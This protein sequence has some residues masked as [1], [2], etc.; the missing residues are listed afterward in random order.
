M[1]LTP[2]GATMRNHRTGIGALLAAGLLLFCAVA[3][4]QPGVPRSATAPTQV[5]TSQDPL[6]RT[7]PRG[8]VLGFLLAAR[9]GDNEAAAQYLNTD[10]HGQAAS[11]LAHELFVVLDRRLPARL[12]QLSDKP[13]GSLPFLTRLDQD[14]VGTITT[15]DG[16]VD[17][18]VERVDRGN[19]NSIWLFSRKTLA[20]IPGL[21]KELDA[22]EVESVIPGFLVENS[23]AGVALFEWLAVLVGLPV[24]YLITS[25]LNYVI[26]SLIRRILRHR[27]TRASLS[28]AEFLP[29]PV[30]LLLIALIIRWGLSKVT[31][32][33][34]A[35]EFWSNTAAVITITACVWLLILLNG[36]VES[37]ML[38]RMVRPNRG[39]TSILTLGRRAVDSMAV[40]AGIL[41]GFHHFGVNLTAALAGLGVGGIAIALAAQKTLENVIG[42]IS[43][44]FD[45]VIREGDQVKVGDQVGFVEHIG[46]RSTRLRTFDRTLVSIPNGQL[47]NVSLENISRRDKYWFHHI[48]SL[49]YDT[50]PS[51]M[52]AVVD[53]ASELLAKNSSVESGSV[54]VRFLGFGTSSLN[55]ELF[56]FVIATDSNQFLKTQQALLLGSMKIVHEAGTRLAYPSQTLYMDRSNGLSV[57]DEEARTAATDPGHYREVR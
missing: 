17:I 46:L 43:L 7:T 14:R 36:V 42:G 25:L 51:A 49:R 21:Y 18:V 24:L 13:E 33:L 15:A 4:A 31:L 30:R 29:M 20:V 19:G 9:K 32:P 16:D 39:A 54:Q 3:S 5:E 53:G 28:D 2:W 35:R 12:S 57:A 40:F 22:Q 47:S 23:I 37:F 48:L 56:A 38:R 10:A 55:V 34:L 26:S 11:A 1:G 52:L 8:T 27:S 50:S 6:G 41:F 44:V 45:Q